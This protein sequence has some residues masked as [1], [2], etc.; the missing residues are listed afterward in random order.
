MTDVKDE[1]K[2]I[3]SSKR[4]LIAIG[5]GVSLVFVAWFCY[6]LILGRFDSQ[7]KSSQQIVIPYQID[8]ML[9][10]EPESSAP[11]EEEKTKFQKVGDMY[12]T[13]GDSY[14]SLNTLFSGLAFAF[15]VASLYLQRKELQAQRLEIE[16]QKKETQRSNEI[17]DE[18]RQ[19]AAN[20]EI[21]ISNQ[22]SEGQKQNFYN[23]LFKFLDEKNERFSRLTIRSKRPNE[24]PD[25]LRDDFLKIFSQS[26]SLAIKDPIYT[27]D[28]KEFLK[29]TIKRKISSMY[30][31]Q[32]SAHGTSFEDYSYFE[33]FVSIL[34]FIKSNSVYNRDES[35]TLIFISYLTKHET[36][37]MA[38]Y[39]AVKN[40]I[41][42]EYIEEFSLLRNIDSFHM[43][44]S[45]KENLK[46]LYSDDAFM[47][48]KKSILSSIAK[49]LSI[50]NH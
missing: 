20:Q 38:Y 12:G 46:V 44:G 25:S 19:I 42:F 45:S 33:Y 29:E 35:I 16:D 7:P 27:G 26:L 30:L 1:H 5:V 31:N 32:T 50:K 41:L 2:K 6:P 21:L 39:A 36:I 22:L 28:D 49:K 3:D 34:D 40:P 4:E 37:C 14:G 23:L 43:V 48:T 11:I 24:Y 18:Q 8:A 13:Y 9:K 10:T 17:A 47:V 15:L